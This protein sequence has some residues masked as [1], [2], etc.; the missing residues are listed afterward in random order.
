M[1][2]L[3]KKD[4]QTIERLFKDYTIEEIA[5]AFMIPREPLSP[6][7]EE[8]GMQEFRAMRQREIANRTPEQWIEAKTLQIKYQILN[9]IEDSDPKAHWD[10]QYFLNE[11]IRAQ[12][13][14]DKEFA[15]DVDV[16]PYVLSQYLNGHRTPPKEFL[17]R[18]ELHSNGL[19]PASWW[20]RSLQK[21][22]EVELAEDTAIREQES[23]HVKNKIE[24]AL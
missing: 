3:T 23:K 12:N 6:E 10:F 21:S 13:K 22:K 4:R 20:L 18:L 24:L 9:Y 11:Y 15:A 8:K 1:R 2:H 5:D 7:E 16:K 14:K 17:V 19:I